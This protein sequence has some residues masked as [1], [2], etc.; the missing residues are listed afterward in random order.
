MNLIPI[1]NDRRQPGINSLGDAAPTYLLVPFD[2]ALDREWTS[3]V[4]F[5]SY[6]VIEPGADAPTEEPYPRINKPA[7]TSVREAGA[8]VV[9]GMLTLDM[10]LQD[11]DGVEG[12]EKPTWTSDDLESFIAAVGHLDEFLAER[13]IGAPHTYTTNHGAR[14]IH[15]LS[16]PVTAEVAED[17][18]RG[19][20][21]VYGE[22]G[23]KLDPLSDWTRLMRAPN[24]LRDGLQTGTQRWF[25]TRWVTGTTNPDAIDPVTKETLYR[26]KYESIE[27]VTGGKPSPE[28]A[29]ALLF[30]SNGR[31]EKQSDMRKLAARILRGTP[32][33]ACIF[34][35]KPIA[36]KGGRD[37]ALIKLVGSACNF[38]L[39]PLAKDREFTPEDI[40]ALFL[41]PVEQL[42]PDAGT[43]DWTQSLWQKVG[44]CYARERAKVAAK[45]VEKEERAD[46]RADG[47]RGLLEVVQQT[48]SAPELHSTDEVTALTALS[49]MLLL[50]DSSGRLRA[51]NPNGD[52][53]DHAFP[54]AGIHNL[55]RSVNMT[56]WIDL[57]KELKSG[58]VARNETEVARDHCTD[59]VNITGAVGIPRSYVRGDAMNN[60]ELVLSLYRRNEKLEPTYSETVAEWLELLT[61]EPEQL[62][63]WIAYALHFE[64]GATC[65]LSLAGAP[66]AGKGLLTQGLIETLANPIR[67]DKSA[68]I[69]DFNSSLARTPFLVVDEGLPQG[70]HDIADTFRS[71]TAGE[72]LTINEKYQAPVRIRNPMRIIF[73]ANNLEVVQQ[74][75][76]HRQ[77]D[78]RDQAALAARLLHLDVPDTAAVYLLAQGGH[79]HTGGWVESA[80]GA[81]SQFTLAK[82][83]LWLHANRANFG[84]PGDRFLVQGRV[85]TE[86]AQR[87]RTASKTAQAV[88]FAILSA[89]ETG[90]SPS[91]QA[92]MSTE[93]GRILVTPRAVI[94]QHK[95]LND[96]NVQL[97]VATVGNALQN[98]LS[99]GTAADGRTRRLTLSG[100]QS[101]QRWK[102]IDALM[103]WRFA[104]EGGL[105]RDT[106]EKI[107][108]AQHGPEAVK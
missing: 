42:E 18:L 7:L 94:E 49:R 59:L 88:C 60:L 30:V 77:R 96:S 97:N 89:L 20:H 65:A 70:V 6:T 79:R 75:A 73:T 28:D 90:I 76:S 92:G 106:L 72:P 61:D 107:V 17:L 98:M 8:E 71:L 29:H 58:T 80:S 105:K 85:Q 82:H 11:Q 44:A 9:L 104:E 15:K 12:D 35:S 102:D 39:G 37:S 32:S 103:L 108:T 2:E 63:R 40:Y 78:A 69:G 13:R 87:M 100:E 22:F 67:A 48:C 62:K 19:L 24:V 27:L 25:W 14:F 51:F 101:R 54:I 46:K 21:K 5:A 53:T 10:D 33:Y 45:A 99:E 3:D 91:V 83:L 64:G 57:T 52:I 43:P 26:D 47:L 74:L 36:E 86:V 31:G 4:H 41:A 38:L 81:P 1:T 68:L 50:R 56:G 23:F 55:I 93:D 34:E 84:E 66:A 95:M 16:K